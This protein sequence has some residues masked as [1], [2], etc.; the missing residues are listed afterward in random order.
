MAFFSAIRRECHFLA[1][2]RS[3]SIFLA[4]V[5]AL[6]IF[7]VLTGVHE[8]QSQQA[9]LTRLLEKDRLDR[10]TVQ[11]KQSDYGNAAYYSFH[12]TYSP[13]Q[14]LAF[15]AM[16]QRDIY[17]WKHRIRMLALEGQIY[18]TDSANPELAFFGRFDFAFIASVLLPLFVIL[19][20]HDLRSSEREAGRFDL[21]VVSSPQQHQLW[22]ARALVLSTALALCLLL[23]FSAA[24]LYLKASLGNSLLSLLAV[25]AH[26]AFWVLVTIALGNAMNQ[27]GQ[28]S[29]RIAAALLGLWLSVS[30]IIPVVSDTLI[31]KFIPHPQ[32]GEIVL[33]QRESVNDA[34]DLP[35]ETTWQAFLSSHPEWRDKTAMKSLFEWKWYYA[36]QQ[37]GD[38][39]AAELSQAYREAIIKKDRAAA[40]AAVLSPPMLTQRLLSTLAKTDT[41]AALAYEQQV[42]NFHR[43]LR[44][45][46]Y[47]LLFNNSEFTAETLQ[48]L[49]RYTP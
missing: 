44:Q 21:L 27:R 13:P 48:Q 15:A 42:R 4:A 3:V 7:S 26:L 47:P 22:A 10:E 17:P 32:G 9:T 16:G 25:F 33:L 20:L 23:P 31:R 6:S 2:Q 14:P 29:A 5:L 30:V 19:L 36:F 43:S 40:F 39:K 38:E 37:V 41:T 46:Y 11:A 8:V 12:L 18:E 35:V 45:F 28:S 49:P 24:A 1:R 34:W